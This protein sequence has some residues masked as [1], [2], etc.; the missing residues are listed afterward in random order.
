MPIIWLIT[1]V[2]D[3]LRARREEARKAIIART[4]RN[5]TEGRV[6]SATLDRSPAMRCDCATRHAGSE[7]AVD[8]PD[9]SRVRLVQ[10]S[11]SDREVCR[12]V[13]CINVLSNPVL[14]VSEDRV[15]ESLRSTRR[16]R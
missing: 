7:R 11:V 10:E 16:M 12:P 14:I 1:L 2:Y 15:S 6:P 13:S 9:N 3:K 5:G 8:G 4:G